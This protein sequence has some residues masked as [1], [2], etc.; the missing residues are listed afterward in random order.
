MVIMFFK[1]LI[2]VREFLRFFLSGLTAATANIGTAWLIRPYTSFGTSLLI[3]L[4]AG[5]SVSFVLSKW[6]AF[7]S[8]SWRQAAVEL[9]R[10]VLVYALGSSVYW[11]ATLAI[12]RVLDSSEIPTRLGDIVSMVVGSAFMMLSSYLGHR[13]F[14]YRKMTIGELRHQRSQALMKTKVEPCGN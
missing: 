14:T 8:F 1:V 4:A 6:F 13:F 3:G 10:F 2:D 7:R 5:F 9:R 12:R 11:I